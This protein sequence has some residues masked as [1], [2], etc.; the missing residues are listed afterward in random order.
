MKVRYHHKRAEEAA[1]R[2]R[3]AKRR[4]GELPPPPCVVRPTGRKNSWQARYWLKRSMGR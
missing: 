3:A 1:D 4:R 2:I